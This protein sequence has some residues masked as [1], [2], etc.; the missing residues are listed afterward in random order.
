MSDLILTWLRLTVDRRAVTA[1][2][3][4]LIAGDI[5]PTI[6]HRK[7]TLNVESPPIQKVLC[8]FRRVT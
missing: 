5:V 6:M 2:E 7:R 1:S 4:G 8:P 3:Y